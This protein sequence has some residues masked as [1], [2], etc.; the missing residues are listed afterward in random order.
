[1]CKISIRQLNPHVF[2]MDDSGEAT[3]YVVVGEK[4][5]LVIDTMNGS[6]DVKAVVRK[7]TDLPLMVVNTHG[8]CD[9]IHGN[10]YF[11]EAY[12]H[13]ADLEL[14]N[15]HAKFPEFVSKIAERGLSM[16]PFREIRGGEVIDLGGL[17]VEV[18]D[19]PGHTKGGIL[20]LLK[21]DRILFTGDGINRHLWLQLP[22]CLSPEEVLKEIDKVRYL[23]EKADTILHGHARDFEPISLIEELWEGLRTLC[24]GK[25]E[26]DSEYSWFGGKARQHPFGDGNSVIVYPDCR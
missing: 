18:I 11:E 10:I 4:K 9:H 21:E 26:E 25:T 24:E 15:E 19:F 20:L 16:P 3:G 6:E 1:M 23:E 22:D 2:L 7:V 14:A 17:N 12:L 13:P 5:A 8:H